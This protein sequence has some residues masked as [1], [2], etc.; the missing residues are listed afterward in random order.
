MRRAL[1]VLVSGGL[2]FLTI[3]T[4]SEWHGQGVAL[5][6]LG[7]GVLILLVESRAVKRLRSKFGDRTLPGEPIFLLGGAL[8]AFGVTIFSASF[9]VPEVNGV[10]VGRS[11]GKGRS[12]Y[13]EVKQ[14]ERSREMLGNTDV[15]PC[16]VGST[17]SKAAWTTAYR[18]NTESVP[19]ASW[20]VY[21]VLA[22]EF[23]ACWGFVVHP[24]VKLLAR[25]LR[26]RL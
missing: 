17:L 19:S 11:S 14:G 21:P 23:L 16:P 24:L 26:L 12:Y 5:V 9:V 18:C 25:R 15:D 3:A 22:L 10:V 1:A 2:T 4:L 20:G 13:L 7:L 8:L 6:L